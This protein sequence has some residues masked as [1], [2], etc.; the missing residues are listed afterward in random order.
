VLQERGV[1]AR[2]K[3]AFLDL[4]AAR[5]IFDKCS[6]NTHERTHARTHNERE[7]KREETAPRLAIGASRCSGFSRKVGKWSIKIQRDSVICE[8]LMMN[9]YISEQKTPRQDMKSANNFQMK[10]DFNGYL[11]Q[12][13]TDVGLAR[14][15]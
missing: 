4:L 2:G 3:V 15:T 5:K 12:R 13:C 1:A 9:S 8:W 6:A 14:D 7:W 11:D 10:S